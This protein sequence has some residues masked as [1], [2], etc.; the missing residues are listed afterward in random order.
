MLFIK[1][2]T[3]RLLCIIGPNKMP[4][5]T[6]DPDIKR[7]D[8]LRSPLVNIIEAGHIDI[9]NATIHKRLE[10]RQKDKQTLYQTYLLIA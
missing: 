2:I 10:P 6:F 5:T 9:Y 7:L 3:G 4:P 8:H 1:E